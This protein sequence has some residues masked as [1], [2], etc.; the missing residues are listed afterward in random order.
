MTTPT[1]LMFAIAST[2][3]RFTVDADAFA[4]WVTDLEDPVFPALPDRSQQDPGG[5]LSDLAFS[6]IEAGVLRG[7]PQLSLWVQ[8]SDDPNGSGFFVFL[9][10]SDRQPDGVR[11]T[12]G[13]IDLWWHDENTDDSTRALDYLNSICA[14]ANALLDKLTPLH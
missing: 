2:P 10:N 6:A 11:V 8:G 3:I 14:H 1:P 7:D 4:R 13:W 9:G 5:R 12:S